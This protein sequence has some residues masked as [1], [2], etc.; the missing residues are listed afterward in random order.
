MVQAQIEKKQLE[1][2]LYTETKGGLK[3]KNPATLLVSP[4]EI[5][6]LKSPFHLKDE[7]KAMQGARWLGFRQENPKKVWKVDN[8]ARNWFQLKFLM[9]QNPY[10]WFD[11]DLVTYE[12]DHPLMDHQKLM[13]DTGL[14]YHYQIW[15]AEMGTGKEARY[16]TPV[17]TPTGWTTMG[18]LEVGQRLIDP[19]GGECKVLSLHPQGRKEIFKVTFTD[20]SSTECGAE[21]L[22]RVTTA[23]WK[24]REQGYQV[25]ELQEL[26][27]RGLRYAN[28][29]NKWYIPM[30][31]PVSFD[32]RKLKCHPYVMGYLLGNGHMPAY[33]VSAPDQETVDRLNSFMSEPLQPTS[34]TVRGE[35]I[36]YTI[37]CQ[38]TRDAIDQ[39][40]L[41]EC[42]ANSKFVPEDFLFNTASN[43]L[44]VLQGLFDSDG[45]P[46]DNAGI[47]FCSASDKLASDVVFLIQSFG[48]TCHRDLKEEPTYTY[49][50]DTLVGQP[51][52]RI[53][54]SFN[55][56]MSPFLLLRKA[57]KYTVPTKYEPTRAIVSVE[58]VGFDDAICIKV[59]SQTHCYVT[60]E[61]IVTHNT[62]SAQSVMELSGVDT[63]FWVGPLKSLENIEREWEKWNFGLSWTI[64]KNGTALMEAVRDNKHNLYMTTYERLV[65][66]ME[67]R[68]DSDPIPGGVIFDES[69]RLKSPT[70]QRSKAAQDL[71]DNIRS[72]FDKEGF[73][74]LMSGTPSPKSPLDWW[75]QCEITWPGFL[76][77]GSK[78][79]L[80]S[81]LGFMVRQELPDNIINVRIGWKDNDEKCLTCAKLREEGA[82]EWDIDEPDKRIHDFEKS[83]NEV[84]YMYERL[85]GLVTIIH[86]KDVLNLPDKIY[87]VDYCE[88]SPSTV[89][90][91]Q[92]VAKSAPNVITGITWLRELSDG[93][94]Y[95]DIPDGVKQCP[96]CA[97]SEEDGHIKSWFDPDAPDDPISDI[98][99]LDQEYVDSLEERFVECPRCSGSQQVPKMKRSSREVPCP[100]EAKLK[101]RLAQC[102]ETGRIIVFAGFQGSIDRIR[103]ICRK[104]G[105]DVVQCDGR[106]WQVFDKSGNIIRTDKP[107]HY[108]ADL[109]H[110]Q[111][112][113]F[114]AHPQSGGLSLNLTESRMAV[115]WS[116]DFNPESR[117]QAED[118]IHRKGMDEN[119]GCKIVD[120]YHLPSD[121][122]VR[123]VLQE[124]RKLELMTMGDLTGFE[125]KG[126]K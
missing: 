41:K 10:E 74:I 101:K 86:K 107:L 75:K 84:A 82:H 42:R 16:S 111:Q 52:H 37:K 118:R 39:Y 23:N 18:A 76:K 9:G 21:H 7:I 26:V 22:W 96:T 45:T 68:S 81:R 28:G 98:G 50:G 8:C 73:V 113:A 97:G 56:N 29:N 94:M 102:E 30:V 51:S 36:D 27:A 59:D 62:L 109:E 17:L 87:E 47:E 114:V 43:R 11:Q 117:S 48:G 92:S 110:H 58:S 79:Q 53:H 71:A 106:G 90:V 69:S 126:S 34:S 105:W 67:T 95:K 112:V 6:F 4:T 61:F 60:D 1:T 20:G 33:Q 40:G 64:P 35:R 54:G 122:K 46:L 120:I 3:I 115:F 38:D 104:E 108:W 125:D 5:E 24:F 89:R 14:T 31:E 44:L 103:G 121:E 99:M 85:N 116:N 13:A 32:E 12:Y 15:G 70:S 66:Y 80:E 93:F 78:D 88:P 25:L 91:A 19:E 100:K 49:K 72:K 77:E 83:F 2:F 57:D 119:K 55:S 123:T 124:N 65:K 63:W